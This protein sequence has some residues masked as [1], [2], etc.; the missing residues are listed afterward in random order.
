MLL[1]SIFTSLEEQEKRKQGK[2]LRRLE[3]IMKRY[4]PLLE[5]RDNEKIVSYQIK[6]IEEVSLLRKEIK[7]LIDKARRLKVSNLKIKAL[8]SKYIGALMD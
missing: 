7:Q 4:L 2:M 3:K 1:F 6:L 5:K 8:V